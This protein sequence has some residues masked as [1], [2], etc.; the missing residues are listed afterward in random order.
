MSYSVSCCLKGIT[1]E[2][3]FC[4]V[5]W[6]LYMCS[7]EPDVSGSCLL[8]FSQYT[9]WPC[10][11]VV[12]LRGLVGMSVP[13]RLLMVCVHSTRSVP[14]GRW[15]AN[16]VGE[17]DL[18]VEGNFGKYWKCSKE[19]KWLP[20]RLIEAKANGTNK[21]SALAGPKGNNKIS[22]EEYNFFFSWLK[23]GSVSL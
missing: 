9:E 8:Q 19:Q 16:L 20:L 12:A 11:V 14:A 17:G 2:D 1:V 13:L 18:R 6:A 5:C 23:T 15:M 21:S 10:C 4:G 3:N 22:F 7:W